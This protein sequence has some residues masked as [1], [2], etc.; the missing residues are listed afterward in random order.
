MF[1]Q[2]LIQLQFKELSVQYSAFEH[3]RK[4]KKVYDPADKHEQDT[5]K[6]IRL[7]NYMISN[8]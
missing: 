7:N 4:V 8:L 6:M 3:P 2:L 5:G 1:I